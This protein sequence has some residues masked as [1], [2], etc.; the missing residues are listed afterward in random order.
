MKLIVTR[1]L[2]VIPVLFG[3]CVLSY[4]LL[5]M[6]PGDPITAMLGMDATPEAIAAL[7]A[8]FALDEPLPLRFISWFGHLL[9][10]DLGRSIQS[11][12]P[13][14]SMVMTAMVPTM[15]LGLA[16]LLISLVI[17]IPAGVISAARRNSV[18]DYSVSLISLAG[19]SLPS[20][21]LA[22]LLVLFL[23]IRLQIFP[24]SGYVPIGEDPVG[25]LR[26]ITLP[27]I[28][29]GVAMAA[30]TMRMTR[31]AML[32]VLNAD[33][34]RTARAKGLPFRR[35]VWKHAL[36]NALIPVTTLVGLQLGQLMGGVVVTETV[37]AWPGIGKLT[38][39]AIFARDY[40][41]VQGAILAS[42]VLFV[43]INLATD[44]LYATLD[45]RLRKRA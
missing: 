1:V 17:A 5:A 9:I 36:R 44:L 40:P 29:L 28:T 42:A 27:A 16:A 11:G 7:R 24:S 4:T 45:P 18:A 2:S 37:F 38:V 35:V 21:W 8:K 20:F 19:L 3:L 10:G 31:A 30:S 6:I 34:I 23:S 43:F 39:D 15:Q 25:A 13:V 32:D 12:R 14:L 33:Y 22:I 26:H 41:V